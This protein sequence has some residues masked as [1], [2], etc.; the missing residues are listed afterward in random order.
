MRGECGCC[1]Q[2]QSVDLVILASWS[3]VSSGCRHSHRCRHIQTGA[4]WSHTMILTNM[5]ELCGHHCMKGDHRRGQVTTLVIC[6]SRPSD[7]GDTSTW[8]SHRQWFPIVDEEDCLTVRYIRAITSVFKTSLHSTKV[9]IMNESCI[10]PR[11]HVVMLQVD[12]QLL[13]TAKNVLWC[14]VVSK[15]VCSC[16]GNT[17]WCFKTL[18]Q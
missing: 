11:I 1:I 16:W 6:W 7:K 10:T 18:L 12:R 3:H 9:P 13:I 8:L 4:P 15:N 5:V 17:T 14:I 2:T